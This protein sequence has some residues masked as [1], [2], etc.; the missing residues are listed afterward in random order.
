[1][2]TTETTRA[3]ANVSTN[4][5]APSAAV[6]HATPAAPSIKRVVFDFLLG[7]VI[8]GLAAGSLAVSDGQAATTLEA[9]G[10]VTTVSYAGDN[11]HSVAGFGRHFWSAL[12]LAT[13]C[14]GLTAFN[15]SLARHLK[16][17]VLPDRGNDH[18]A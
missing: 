11:A 6:M 17:E 12:L 3:T 18:R 1:M 5:T 2:T 16:A 13:T 15:L 14:G 8:F 7:F 9:N 4:D 10:W